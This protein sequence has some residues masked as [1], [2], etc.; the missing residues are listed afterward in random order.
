MLFSF[1]FAD[2]M[3]DLSDFKDLQE[4]VDDEEQQGAPPAEH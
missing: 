1:S 2:M 4:D 3:T